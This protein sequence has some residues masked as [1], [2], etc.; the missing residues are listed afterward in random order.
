M[1]ANI[2]DWALLIAAHGEQREDAGNESIARLAAA[3]ATRGAAPEISYGFLS[4][5]PTIADAVEA[6]TGLEII[7][8]PLFL[9]EGYFTRVCTFDGERCE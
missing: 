5:T 4:G 7:V 2:A 8:Y 6:L 9:S 3:P 1:N